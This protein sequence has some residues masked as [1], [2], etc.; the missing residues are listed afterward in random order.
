MKSSSLRPQAHQLTISDVSATRDSLFEKSN[1]GARTDL[2]EGES[3]MQ[4]SLSREEVEKPDDYS[5]KYLENYG[6]EDFLVRIR[7]NQL[8]SF[9]TEPDSTVLEV[10]CGVLSASVL[11][12]EVKSWTILE[13]D[14][15]FQ[16]A[17][18]SSNSRLLNLHLED[19]N[20]KQTETFSHIIVSSILHEIANLEP[21]MVKLRELSSAITRLHFNTPNSESLHRRVG[22]KAGLLASFDSLSPRALYLNQKRTY[23]LQ[24]LVETMTHFGFEVHRSGSYFLKPF[25]NDQLWQMLQHN[26][27]DESILMAFCEVFP[28]LNNIT[29]GAEIFVE[30]SCPRKSPTLTD[31]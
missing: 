20:P 26:I 21:F 12:P 28:S 8:K 9:I 7:Q 5:K 22:E 24:S 2:K 30:C 17:Q 16:N 11:F 13:P 15:G 27:I 18:R 23:S 3:L 6:L 25:T 1:S 19:F 31:I 10:G 29:L 4:R 14:K